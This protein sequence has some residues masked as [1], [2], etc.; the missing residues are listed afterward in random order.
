MCDELT[1][2]GSAQECRRRLD[3]LRRLGLKMP[4]VAPFPVGGDAMG[5]FRA[6]IEALAP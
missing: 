1:V 3:S 6:V 4:V 2:V 5:S